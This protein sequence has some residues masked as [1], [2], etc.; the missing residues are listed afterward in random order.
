MGYGLFLERA[1]VTY[2]DG[3]GGKRFGFARVCD[4]ENESVFFHYNDGSAVQ[5][6]E[7]G[8]MLHGE[9]IGR[10]P[11]KGDG[12]VFFRT[13]GLPLPKAAPWAYARDYCRE[14][15]QYSLRFVEEELLLNFPFLGEILLD[16]RS[17]E[18]D[19]GPFSISRM[20]VT[21]KSLRIARRQEGTKVYLVRRRTEAKWAIRTIME[22]D[23]PSQAT[24]IITEDVLDAGDF[25]AVVTV[26]F[27]S[28]EMP[29][30]LTV[31]CL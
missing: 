26:I 30:S 16:V 20:E 22:N 17:H 21:D 9:K 25:W 13:E 15:R 3:R 18:G 7:D 29:L 2:F 14:L 10:E 6:S 23:G 4:T 28:K 19:P 11:K 24:C 12:I 27:A 5:F 31:Y 8:P 1:I